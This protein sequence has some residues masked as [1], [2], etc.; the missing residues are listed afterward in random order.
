MLKF[1]VSED[2]N[3]LS[4]VDYSE[5]FERKQIEI[6]L[7]KKIH[8]HF[9]HPLVKKKHWDGAICFVDKKLPVWRV[10]MGLWSEVYQI[11]QKYK[12]EVSIE[13]LHKVIDQDFTLEKYT[14]WCN[15]FFKDGVGGDPNKMPRDYQI[16]TAWKIIKFKL[17]V[18]EIATSSGK[19]LIAFMVMAY[20]KEVMQVKKFLMVVP[21]T[22]LVIQGSEDFEEYG[23]EKLEDCEIQQIHGANKKKISG[24]LMIGTYQSLVKMEP[25]FFDGVEAVFVDECHQAQSASIKK[26]VSL[27]KDSKWRFGLS[28]TL[29]NKNTAE[30]LTIQ[31]FL[32]PLIMEISPKF[33]FD[34]KYA[35]PVSIKI[36]KMDW[37]DPDVKQKLGTLKETKTE[38]EGNEIFNIERKL[39]VNSEKRLDY[40]LNFILKT[41]KNSLVLFQSVGEGYGKRLYEGIRGRVS[42]REVYYIDGDTEPTKREIFLNRMEEGTNRVLVAS[43][44]TLSTGIS[45][46]NIHNIFLTESYKSEVLIKQSLGRGMRLFEGKEKVNIIDFVDDF[47]WE[48]KDN[49]LLKH[50]KERIEIYKKEHFDYKIYEIKI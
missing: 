12:I 32:G 16:E 27:C 46:K 4:L 15:E 45:I 23:L 28:G 50:C 38:I 22:N 31:Q 10:P 24:G 42:D 6:S 36:V 7:T 25:E 2:N 8:N 49:Y 1:V 48:G 29:A 34:N 20:L 33:L 14:E 43:F 17:S 5:D 11:C 39:V 21:N 19:T 26:V 35:T 13:G 41:S 30:Y 3:W 37:L 44:G 47:S 18:S 9:F 40:V